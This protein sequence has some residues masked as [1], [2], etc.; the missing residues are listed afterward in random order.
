MKNLTAKDAEIK[1]KGE[2][3]ERCAEL[4]EVAQSDDAQA[5]PNVK[6]SSVETRMVLQEIMEV[7]PGAW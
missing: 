4:V 1:S 2:N 7:T 6:I 3:A 5:S